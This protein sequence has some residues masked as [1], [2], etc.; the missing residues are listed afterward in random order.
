VTVPVFGSGDILSPELAKKMFD[1][2]G[3]DG[4][5]V[6]RGSLGNPWIFR[7]IAEYLSS[8]KITAAPGLEARKTALKRHLEY[9]EK[10]KDLKSAGKASYSRKVVTWYIKGFENAASIRAKV[11]GIKTFE[12]M[13]TL[14]YSLHTA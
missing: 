1:E 7:G 14:V 10:N 3:C 12:D 9:I 4:I 2:T 8:G 6:A 13:K 11:S 5:L